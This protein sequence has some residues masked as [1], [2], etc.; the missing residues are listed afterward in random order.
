M[1]PHLAFMWVLGVKLGSSGL[2]GVLVKVSIAVIIYYGSES[3]YLLLQLVVSYPGKSE[4]KVEA[5]TD[6]EV[7]E[8][9]SLLACSM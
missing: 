4:Q 1:P 7:M 2:H 9:C 5:S 3:V 8:E 6:A